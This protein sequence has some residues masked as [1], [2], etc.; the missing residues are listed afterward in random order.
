MKGLLVQVGLR[1]ADEAEER[2]FFRDYVLSRRQ[3]AQ[4]AMLLGSLVYYVFFV[5]DRIID[6][7]NWH[8]THAIR[9]L[10]VTPFL[11]AST[12]LLFVPAF[13]R[14]METVL[15]LF[16][17]VPSIGLSV[18]CAILNRGFDFGGGGF[19]IVILFVFALLYIRIVYF[20]I[21]GIVSWGS[22]VTSQ[23]FFGPADTGLM[24]LNN[25]CIGAAIVLGMFAAVTREYAAR[26]EFRT[27]RQL[28]A[29]RERVEELLHSVLPR[30]IVA[31]IQGGETAI[32]DAH[33]E[34][35]I[36]FA[37]IVGFTELS[38][39]I[40]AKQLVEVLNL[41][42]S[43]FDTEAERHGIEKIK[44]IGD[45]YMAVG[46]LSGATSGHA[47]RAADFA[48]ALT[49]AASRV[50]D[51][52]RCPIRVR[53]S[54][55]VGAVVAGVIGTTRPAF[56][57]WGEAVNVASRLEHHARPGRVVISEAAYWR[58]R[59]SFEAEPLD[60]EVELRGIGRAKAFLLEG[61][62]P[63]GRERRLAGTVLAGGDGI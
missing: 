49:R 23:A 20:T 27:A 61:R 2:R 28:D 54:L 6:P 30:E 32:A 24:I 1:F 31:R 48:L 10:V 53:V 25:M 51:L 55:H 4:A 44:T 37:D 13:Q 9:G 42:F 57:C 22:F 63:I 33:S 58:L 19:I 39:R 46:G 56:D 43:A 62:V 40:S 50:S 60:D 3:Y 47:E 21:F 45:A 17:C 16:T 11:G 29:S 7:Q 41:L 26:R 15:V 5:W 8:V 34:V 14:R 52:T 18:I 12:L 35:S 36:V 59:T 38:R